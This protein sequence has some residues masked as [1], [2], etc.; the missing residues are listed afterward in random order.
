[1]VFD[2]SSKPVGG[3]YDGLSQVGGDFS[4]IQT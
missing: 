2:L 1:M 4:T 3:W